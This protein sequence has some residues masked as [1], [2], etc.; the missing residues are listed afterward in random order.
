VVAED[1]GIPVL[2][3]PDRTGDAQVGEHAAEDEHRVLGAGVFGIR[4]DA[5]ERRLGLRPLDLE[6]GHEHDHLRPPRSARR[7]GRSVAR[8][9]KLVKYWM[10]P[11][12]KRT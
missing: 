9:L 12:S 10:Y 3:G 2:V 6:L 4:L 7:T 8:K 5:L 11:A 1:A